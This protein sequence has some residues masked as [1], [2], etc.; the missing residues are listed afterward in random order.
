MPQPIRTSRRLRLKR[1]AVVSNTRG[2]KK[3][4]LSGKTGR[5]ISAGGGQNSKREQVSEK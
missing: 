1:S 2:Q 4:M 5:I 3:S